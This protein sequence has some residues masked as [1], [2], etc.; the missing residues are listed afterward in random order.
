MQKT[1]LAT[2]GVNIRLNIDGNIYWGVVERYP[3]NSPLKA[4]IGDSV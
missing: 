2:V 3:V 4:F 1:A